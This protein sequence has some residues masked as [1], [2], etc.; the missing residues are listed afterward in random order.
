MSILNVVG[1]V[2]GSFADDDQIGRHRFERFRV[3]FELFER[4]ACA[5]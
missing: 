1:N 2:I 5:E 3:R 4:R